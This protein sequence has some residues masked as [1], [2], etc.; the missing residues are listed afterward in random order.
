M[1]NYIVINGKKAELTEEQLKALGIGVKKK[2]NNP[3]N[4]KSETNN[5][6]YVTDAT[7]LE[8]VAPAHEYYDNE[9]WNKCMIERAN[10]FND[11]AF[12]NQVYLHELLN[13][14]LLKYA[15]DNEAEDNEWNWTASPV[16]K[17]NI[18]YF[19]YKEVSSGDQ[20]KIGN[21]VISRHNEVYFSKE[22]VAQEAIK[23]VIEPFMK[24][25]PEFVW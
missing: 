3:F 24:E 10:S 20:F 9:N 21:D 2:R 1:E 16:C 23:D 17:G 12:A 8:G 6:L 14:K 22:Q 25:H 11:K 4:N 19:I 5:T 13:R 15:W 18:H 7:H